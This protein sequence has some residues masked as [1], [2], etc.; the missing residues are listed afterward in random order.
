MGQLLASCL[1]LGALLAHR[2]TRATRLNNWDDRFP[3][4]VVVVVDS[5][6]CTRHGNQG[7]LLVLDCTALEHRHCCDH[8][9]NVGGTLAGWA[10]NKHLLGW[11]TLSAPVVAAFSF[12]WANN[13]CHTSTAC[14]S[15]FFHGNFGDW[16][17]A[18]EGWILSILLH[19]AS[20]L[21]KVKRTSHMF[22][23]EWLC[24]IA[25]NTWF[26]VEK[27]AEK[28]EKRWIPEITMSF[29]MCSCLLFA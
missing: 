7:S 10:G 9:A 20:L 21:L 29:Y 28:S 17:K 12:W 24:R 2:E 3:S 13:H 16:L 5:D 23:V 1:H 26:L 14:G 27:E 11:Y 25:A 8:V 22:E 4:M 15:N 6:G 18:A 19:L